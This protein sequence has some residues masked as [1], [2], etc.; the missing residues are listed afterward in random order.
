MVL[1]EKSCGRRVPPASCLFMVPLH[2]A[3]H[4]GAPLPVTVQPLQPAA[5]TWFLS[6]SFHN[7]SFCINGV[8]IFADFLCL[9]SPPSPLSWCIRPSSSHDS[10]VLSVGLFEEA[11]SFCESHKRDRR[12]THFSSLLPAEDWVMVQ[13]YGVQKNFYIA[14][15]VGYLTLSEQSRL[16][17][18]C[19]FS[20]H[21]FIQSNVP[22]KKQGQLVSG[23]TEV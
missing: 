22:L 1:L 17:L 11:T 19:L 12:V 18:H 2:T 6:T 4:P 10:A 13:V 9:R 21:F 14:G 16:N 8:F 5:P 15:Q 23:V 3:S 20:R 7:F